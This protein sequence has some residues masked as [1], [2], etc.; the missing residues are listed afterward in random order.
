M[1]IFIYILSLFKCYTQ[2]LTV[3]N[4]FY[5]WLYDK[6]CTQGAGRISVQKLFKNEGEIHS[7]WMTHN[8]NENEKNN[9]DHRRFKTIQPY[10]MWCEHRITWWYIKSIYI[11][12]KSNYARVCVCV[13]NPYFQFHGYSILLIECNLLMNSN[14]KRLN[15]MMRK[16]MTHT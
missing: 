6:L 16:W 4:V 15:M 2:Q 14:D 9:G 13:L 5:R 10:V 8:S 11:F 7:R 1:I 12:A 3:F